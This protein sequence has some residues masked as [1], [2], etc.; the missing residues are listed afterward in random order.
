[1]VLTGGYRL[2]EGVMRICIGVMF[3]T[4]IVTAALVWP[5]LMAV[6]QELLVPRMPTFSGQGLAWTVAL[7]GGVG[8]TLTVLCYGYWIREEG[9]SGADYV[10]VC[11][12]DLGVCYLVTAIFG[13]GMVIIGSTVEIDAAEPRYRLVVPTLSAA[14]VVLC[15]LR[16]DERLRRDALRHASHL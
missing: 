12:I 11:R 1:M 5:G 16:T 7:L 3:V 10:R 4:V 8:G 6:E 9:R 15:R 2:F 14:V 13:V